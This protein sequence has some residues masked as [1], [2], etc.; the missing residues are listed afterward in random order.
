MIMTDAKGLSLAGGIIGSADT[1][2]NL[3]PVTKPVVGVSTWILKDKGYADPTS[4]RKTGGFHFHHADSTFTKV[5]VPL[6]NSPATASPFYS[7]IAFK[8]V[9]FRCS[10]H[11][12]PHSGGAGLTFDKSYGCWPIDDD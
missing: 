5:G 1:V 4:K 10:F 7:P 11:E 12:S 3:F 9:G 6:D 8:L 2:L